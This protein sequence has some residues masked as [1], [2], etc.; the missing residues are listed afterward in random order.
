[1]SIFALVSAN[2][3]LRLKMQGDDVRQLQL[4]LARLGYPLTGTGYFGGATDTAV[5]DF[6]RRH[7]LHVDGDVGP[8]TARAI[9]IGTGASSVDPAPV[10][11]TAR[12]LWLIEAMSRVGIVE[13]AGSRDNPKIIEWAHELG[14]NIAAAYTHDS[15]PWCA[16]FIDSCL[17]RVGE[18]GTGTLW[19]LDYANYGINLHAPALGAIGSMRRAGGGHVIFVLGRD[20]DGNIV[21]VG[22]NQSDKVCIR[23]F[24]PD[25]FEAFTWPKDTPVPQ[26]LGFSHLPLVNSSGL[27]IH[28]A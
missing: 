24:P 6:Q 14:G 25:R 7:G 13:G 19:A 9:D 21:G 2:G 16:L 20:R 4:A 1:M 26:L 15:I 8:I 27:S 22:G 18:K 28:E 12:P 17:Y 3:P 10:S 23:S 5:E 11:T